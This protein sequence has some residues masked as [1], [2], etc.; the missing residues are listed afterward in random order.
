MHFFFLLTFEK[1]ADAAGAGKLRAEPTGA[2]RIPSGPDNS[3]S[4]LGRSRARL[5]VHESTTHSC[6]P[7]PLPDKLHPG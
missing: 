3:T 6:D 2:V 5:N 4:R 7:A 1:T